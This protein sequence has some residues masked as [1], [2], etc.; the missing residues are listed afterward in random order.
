MQHEDAKDLSHS[1]PF[2]RRLNAQPSARRFPVQ[3]PRPKISG[4]PKLLSRVWGRFAVEWIVWQV[5]YEYRPG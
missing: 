2:L 1:R 5:N 4:V 3:K